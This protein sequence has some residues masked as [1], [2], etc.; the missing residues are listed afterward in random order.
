MRTYARSS[1]S[2]DSPRAVVGAENQ[3]CRAANRNLDVRSVDSGPVAR[4]QLSRGGARCDTI[5]A[6]CDPARG[7]TRAAP[8]SAAQRG[9][10]SEYVGREIKTEGV[11]C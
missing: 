1:K 6:L 8:R 5:Y 10:M 11:Q 3:A 7:D 2:V 4:L 9:Y